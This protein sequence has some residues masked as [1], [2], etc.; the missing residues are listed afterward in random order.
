M[1]RPI[2]AVLFDLG[3]VLIEL[4]GASTLLDW[5]G[6]RYTPE[7]LWHLWLTSPVVRAFET[8][9]I[10]AQTF[11]EQ[12]IAAFDLPV[13]RSAFLEAFTAWPR[14]VFPG[15]VEV[16]R[17]I[18]LQYVRATLSNT[19]VLHW[20]RAMEEMGLREL[21]DYQCASHLL[22]H[23]KPDRAVFDHVV[24]TLGCAPSTILFLDDQ[25]LNVAAAQAL[26]FQAVCVQ[27]I[28][29]VERVL[30]QAGVLTATRA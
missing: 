7:E 6:H 26:G 14:G 15:A 22:G 27:G 11:A 8:G 9:H 25:P 1:T 3:G 30:T 2:R 4:T 20:P 13:S 5:M 17:R 10:D 29:D 24:A 18:A 12:L 19:N 16:V 23:F 28:H 21:F